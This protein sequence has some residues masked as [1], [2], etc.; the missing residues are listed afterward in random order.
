MSK[1]VYEEL[2]VE[3]LSPSECKLL[4]VDDTPANLNVLCELLEQEGYNISIGLNVMM[5]GMKLVHERAGL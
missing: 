1:A 3:C 2:C 4:L 5:P